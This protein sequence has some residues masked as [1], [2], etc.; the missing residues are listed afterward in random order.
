MKQLELIEIIDF[1]YEAVEASKLGKI[2]YTQNDGKKI[3]NHLPL[4]AFLTILNSILPKH[5]GGTI[6]ME[7]PKEPWQ[8]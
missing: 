3:L 7:E 5:M 2:D 8:K 6:T 4:Q 1:V